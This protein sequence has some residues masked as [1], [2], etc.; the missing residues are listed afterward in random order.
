MKSH[1]LPQVRSIL[2][3]LNKNLS[4]VDFLDIDEISKL[5]LDKVLEKKIEELME[6]QIEFELPEILH[7]LNL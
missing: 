4:K 1:Y 7:P 5:K 2:N 3:E 6:K